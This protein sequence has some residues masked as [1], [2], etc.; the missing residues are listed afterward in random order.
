M[1]GWTRQS[2]EFAS[3]LKNNVQKSNWIQYLKEQN[4]NFNQRLVI[5]NNTF[6]LFSEI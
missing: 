3:H 4:V 5:K 1:D 6:P 2:V